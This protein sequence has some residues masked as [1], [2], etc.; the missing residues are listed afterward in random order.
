MLLFKD[1][2]VLLAENDPILQASMNGILTML[3]AKVLLA[4][5]NEQ[6]YKIC[7]NMP[8]D[9]I[10]SDLKLLDGSDTDFIK[11]IRKT[12]YTTPIIILSTIEEQGLLVHT[13]NLSLDGYLV[14]PVQIEQLSYTI[15]KAIQRNHKVKEYILLTHEHLYNLNTKELSKGSKVINLGVKEQELIQ[16]LVKNRHRTLSKIEILEALWPFE[17]KSDA[18]LKNIILRIRKK[19]DE[20]A[21][22]SVRG[23]GYRLNKCY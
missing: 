6:A 14:K 22:I 15:C 18:S 3:F 12:D 21:I 2:T 4:S 19:T 20:K 23:I 13:K 8:P 17:S 11:K 9:I 10:I 5:N 1:K 7:K 16:L